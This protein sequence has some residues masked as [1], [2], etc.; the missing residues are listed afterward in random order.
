M[1]ARAC[2]CRASRGQ[3][4]RLRARGRGGGGWRALPTREQ[5]NIRRRPG[6]AALQPSRAGARRGSESIPTPRPPGPPPVSHSPPT[7][8]RRGRIGGA[9][10]ARSLGGS[11]PEGKRGGEN[12]REMEGQGPEGSGPAGTGTKHLMVVYGPQSSCLHQG[13][14]ASPVEH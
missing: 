8:A 4:P 11:S 5:K 3:K 12:A 13:W 7:P 1:C 2:V 9:A 6:R 14:R 10:A